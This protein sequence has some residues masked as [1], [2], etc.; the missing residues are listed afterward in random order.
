MW[1][2]GFAEPA[3]GGAFVAWAGQYGGPQAVRI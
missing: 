3:W 2:F 1:I